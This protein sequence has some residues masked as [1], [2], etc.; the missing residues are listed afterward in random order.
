MNAHTAQVVDAHLHFWDRDRFEYAWLEGEGDFLRGNF[1][2]SDVEGDLAAAGVRG[3]AAVVAVEADRRADQALAEAAWFH[4]LAAAGAPIVSVVASAPL[5]RGAV[6]AE[7]LEALAAMPLVGGVRRLLQDEARGFSLQD[8]FV[9]GVR[10]LAE[11]ELTMDLCI[12]Q[13]QMPDAIALAQLCPD[14]RF[15]LDH[16]GKPRIA[17]DAFEE[18]SAAMTRLAACP[19]VCKVSGL[20][21]EAPPNMRDSDA[22]RPWIYVAL[23]EFGPQRCLFGSD[24]PLVATAASYAAWFDAVSQALEGA[25]ISDRMGVM[26]ANALTTYVSSRHTSRSEES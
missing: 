4:E 14:V 12:R 15:V 19:N 9:A 22:L 1:L 11:L 21:T 2:P 25:S 7:H 18:W 5:E 24:W 20:V 8:D 26:G 23:R 3:D 17:D 10:L 6:C 16:L 13:S